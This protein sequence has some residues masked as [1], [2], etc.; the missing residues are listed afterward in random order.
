M[1][2]ALALVFAL[3]GCQLVFPLDGPGD[4]GT[5]LVQGR[6]LQDVAIEDGS[7]IPGLQ[8][9]PFSPDEVKLTV[10]FADTPAMPIDYNTDGTFSFTRPADARYR[11]ALFH[12]GDV[13]ELQSSADT[14]VY[15][16]KR[17][18][19]LDATIVDQNTPVAI[20]VGTTPIGTPAIATT[21]VW[22]RIGNVAAPGTLDWRTT[23]PR[24]L[25]G[26]ATEVSPD[27]DH[28]Y[29][30]EY[31]PD[32]ALRSDQIV[33]SHLVEPVAITNGIGGSI[34]AAPAVTSP[35]CSFQFKAPAADE[36]TRILPIVPAGLSIS[37]DWNVQASPIASVDPAGIEIASQHGGATA[38]TDVTASLAMFSPFP[39][40]ELVASMSTF[41]KVP[42]KHP[43]AL[44]ATALIVGTTHFDKIGTTGSCMDTSVGNGVGL[45]DP[46]FELDDVIVSDG[47]VITRGA[48]TELDWDPIDATAD[49]VYDVRLVEITASGPSTLLFERR[50]YLTTHDSILIAGEDL[51]PGRR[52]L[53]VVA[54]IRGMPAAG[55]GDFRTLAYPLGQSLQVSPSFAIQP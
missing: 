10:A 6:W 43:E 25:L 30:L 19:R 14:I 11:L 7:G 52:Y 28:V 18:G 37:A 48:V 34:T 15:S 36:A 39:E 55:S 21:G 47:D 26:V 29:Y 13:V 42:V 33:R 23:Q 22:M 51:L 49:D 40:T 5:D 54:G 24:N 50:R 9:V 1:R 46:E 16:T 17:F 3:A 8:E 2:A 41:A 27:R 32:G 31:A 44:D 35:N 4:G 20:A 45:V 38:A 12:G 53:A